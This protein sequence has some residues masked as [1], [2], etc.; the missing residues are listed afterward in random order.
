MYFRVLRVTFLEKRAWALIAVSFGRNQSS[1]FGQN[2]NRRF[3]DSGVK[4]NEPKAGFYLLTSQTFTLL[5]RRFF[6]F[7]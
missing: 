6:H 5:F 3:G 4:I 7:S 1:D 2:L